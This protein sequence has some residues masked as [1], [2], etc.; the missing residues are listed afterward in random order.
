MN[1]VEAGIRLGHFRAPSRD[2]ARDIVFGTVRAALERIGGGD[3]P[4]RH[5][6]RVTEMCLHALRADPRRI[7]AAL[8]HSLPVSPLVK[9]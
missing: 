7:A 9:S 3:A 6:E 4:A 5:G 8:E 1:D 2:A